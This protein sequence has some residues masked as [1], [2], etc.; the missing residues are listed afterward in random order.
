MV[1]VL[2]AATALGIEHFEFIRDELRR[3]DNLADDIVAITDVAAYAEI[4][5]VIDKDAT[6]AT[7]IKTHSE[8]LCKRQGAFANGND[9]PLSNTQN[10]AYVGVLADA[11]SNPDFLCALQGAGGIGKYAQRALPLDFRFGGNGPV[12]YLADTYGRDNVVA[13]IPTNR[14]Q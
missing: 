3:C 11:D 1:L 10:F 8:T 5:C 2:C 14:A 9:E 4:I 6:N 12:L 13:T 7:R